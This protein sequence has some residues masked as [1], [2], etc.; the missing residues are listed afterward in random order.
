M[1]RRLRIQARL[2]LAFGIILAM[3]AV[4]AAVGGFGLQVSQKAIQGITQKLI[5]TANITMAARSQ[6]LQSRAAT[7]TLVA[8]IFNKEAL[9]RARK[10]WDTAQAGLDQ[11]MDDFGAMATEQTGKDNLAKFRELMAAYR[12]AARPAADKLLADG[13]ADSQSAFDDMKAADAAYE[14]ALAMLTNIEAD[15]KKR[16]D[17]IFTKVDGMVGSAF[18][19]FLVAFAVCV[20]VGAVLAVQISRSIIG[21][22]T[23]AKRFAERMAGGDLSRAPEASGKDESAEMMQALAAMQKS[24]SEIVGQV[25]ESA[26]SIQVASSEVAS[27]NMDLSH[28]TEQTASNLQQ[29]SSSMTQLT[30]TVSQSADSAMTAKQLAGAA[31]ETAGRGGEVVS[32]VVS[33]MGEINNAS[34]KIADI[35]GTIDGIAFQTNI[36]ALNAAV[37]AARAGEQGRGFAVVAGEVRSLAQR[38]AEAARE[39][40]GLIG[41]SVER[42]EAGTSLV[43]DAG[44]TMTDIVGSVQRVTDIIGEISAAAAEQ[45][46]GIAQVNGTVMELDQMT[47]QNAALVEESAA[48]AQSLKEQAVRLAGLVASF[49]LS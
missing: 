45:S 25:R 35:I 20:I 33:T 5:P 3:T 1:L 16:G 36:L 48:A 6:L 7:S 49:K 17:A 39:I 40:K 15:L 43:N 11:A 19:V 44:T 42:V 47:Q 28:R 38:S 26:E 21:P 34:K 31:A 10:E 37:E 22:L 8:S 27:G 24:L 2:W 32:R 14:P 9:A 4:L 46:Q 23:A 41:A 30:G 18:I 12:K 29:A 13:Y